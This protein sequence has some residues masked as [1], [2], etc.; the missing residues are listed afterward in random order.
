MQMLND[1]S[2]IYYY[3]SNDPY[4]ANIPFMI[5][6]RRANRTAAPITM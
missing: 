5:N 2:M 1:A 4:H 3:P 6:V